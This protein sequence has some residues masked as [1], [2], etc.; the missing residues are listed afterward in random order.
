[1]K[2]DEYVGL[3][4][5]MVILS[6]LVGIGV[7]S[8]L[9]GKD[10]RGEANFENFTFTKLGISICIMF[11]YPLVGAVAIRLCEL[12]RMWGTKGAHYKWNDEERLFYGAFWP[13]TT[14]VSL[15]IYPFLGIMHRLY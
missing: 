6:L 11:A 3:K 7:F 1:M 2:S 10:H 12:L 15:V 5:T 9:L 4:A 14:T 13:V 8:I